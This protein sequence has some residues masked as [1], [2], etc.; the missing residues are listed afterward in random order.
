MMGR[1]GGKVREIG[2]RLGMDV[3]RYSKDVEMERR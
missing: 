2:K 1:V 3:L